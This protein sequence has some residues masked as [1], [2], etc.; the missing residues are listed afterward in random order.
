MP[1]PHTPPLKDRRKWKF[2]IF[3]HNLY[4]PNLFQNK[5]LFRNSLE[6][7]L[8]EFICKLLERIMKLWGFQMTHYIFF[9]FDSKMCWG[10]Q[11]WM[12]CNT[13]FLIFIK[14]YLIPL[15]Q[16][17]NSLHTPVCRGWHICRRSSGCMPNFSGCTG[18]ATNPCQ[19]GA[20]QGATGRVHRVLCLLIRLWGASIQGE[21]NYIWFI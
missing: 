19:R 18:A 2:S 1:P 6:I 16:I 10:Q 13:F 7:I 4:M 11:K 3:K 12:I 21:T 8:I 17:V 5:A 14:F 9:N 20:T 15:K